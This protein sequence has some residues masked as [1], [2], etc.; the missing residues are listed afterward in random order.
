[1][2]VFNRTLPFKV[3]LKDFISS[4]EI[5]ENLI[6]NENNISIYNRMVF[7]KY[8]FHILPM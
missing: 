8:Y 7:D 6:D 4:Q 5:M 3:L 1:M 2:E